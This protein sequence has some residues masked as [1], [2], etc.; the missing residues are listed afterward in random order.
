MIFFKDCAEI[1]RN[2][3]TGRFI[4][5]FN[6]EWVAVQW[7][8]SLVSWHFFIPVSLAKLK[9]FLYRSLLTTSFHL[10]FGLPQEVGPLT[11]K[12]IIFFV[13]DVSSC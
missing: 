2:L 7:P 4:S 8:P 12:F 5:V 13:H 6:S 3:L 1:V 11:T 10:N 9:H